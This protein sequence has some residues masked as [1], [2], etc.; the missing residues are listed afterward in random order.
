MWGYGRIGIDPSRHTREVRPISYGAVEEPDLGVINHVDNQEA[1]L[2]SLSV[3]NSQYHNN[4]KG[5]LEMT[6]LKTA[7]VLCA[8]L[9]GLEVT[10]EG[11]K[12]VKVRGDR[13]NP[14]SEGYVFRKGLNIKHYQHHADRLSH[15]LKK[16]GGG[17]ERVSW[18]QALSEIAE[19]L[20]AIIGEHGPRSL[21]LVKGAGFLGCPSQIP[22]AGR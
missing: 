4:K 3:L 5:V 18:D 8:N 14:R 9:C 19:R 1:S 2:L 11:N 17:F 13:D 12:I 16:V 21:A 20:T 10:V 6:V 22:F 7:C 15:P